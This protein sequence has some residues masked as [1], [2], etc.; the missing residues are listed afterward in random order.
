M[1]DGDPYVITTPGVIVQAGPWAVLAFVL[2]LVWEI[3]QVRLYTI[4]A[5]A[6]GMSVAS[7]LFHGTLGDVVIALAAFALAGVVLWRADWPASRPC[8]GGLIVVIGAMAFTV[9]TR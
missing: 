1:S 9:S 5:T 4:C 2:H 6:D 3:A 7:A 8:L